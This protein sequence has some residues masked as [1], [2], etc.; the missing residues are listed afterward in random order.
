MNGATHLL[1]GRPCLWDALDALHSAWYARLGTCAQQETLYARLHKDVDA[2]LANLL[3]FSEST[4][5][6]ARAYYLSRVVAHAA[7]DG[8][9][10][11]FVT[12]AAAHCD[13]TCDEGDA[14]N[15]HVSSLPYSAQP[16]CQTT[17]EEPGSC[18]RNVALRVASDRHGPGSGAAGCACRAAL[19]AD[20]ARGAPW[21]ATL[22]DSAHSA[23]PIE[24]AVQY[25]DCAK[26]RCVIAQVCSGAKTASQ[27]VCSISAG[28]C[29]FVLAHSDSIRG[30]FFGAAAFPVGKQF[31]LGCARQSQAALSQLLAAAEAWVQSDAEW[32]AHTTTAQPDSALYHSDMA[33]LTH[34]FDAAQPTWGLPE[35]L[36]HELLER[37]GY[38]HP[39]MD[40][41]LVYAAVEDV[42]IR[43]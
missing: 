6:S 13:G 35:A 36:P 7:P 39:A 38:E 10:L 15:M 43:D 28:V 3:A 1:A 12:A 26:R 23:V 37:L 8:C 32:R 4:S 19:C 27:G 42:A 34:T 30:L 24:L 2:S 31:I 22:L 40:S 18:V 16:H 21:P 33:A 14:A 25:T 29:L 5:V 17:A 41:L 20:L 11:L 9:G